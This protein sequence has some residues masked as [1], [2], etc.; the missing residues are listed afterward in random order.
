MYDLDA[1]IRNLSNIDDDMKNDT[2]NNNDP[3]NFLR[4]LK[5]SN[6]NR[7]IIG[8]LNINSLRIKF[9]ALKYIIKVLKY[10]T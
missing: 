1:E 6:V 2:T 3:A 10:I 7:L 5:L 8:Q 9:G 4:N